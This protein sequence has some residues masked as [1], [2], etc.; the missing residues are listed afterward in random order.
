MKQVSSYQVRYKTWAAFG[1][2]SKFSKSQP[3]DLYERRHVR[4]LPFHLCC[5]SEGIGHEFQVSL[6]KDAA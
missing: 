2:D 3:E 5:T 6:P 4:V 1:G